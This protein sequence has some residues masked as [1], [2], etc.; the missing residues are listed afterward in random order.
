MRPWTAN[1]ILRDIIG[2]TA[3]ESLLQKQVS[4]HVLRHSIAS[5][6]LEQGVSIYQVRL[7]LGHSLLETTQI[8]THINRQQ[9]KELIQ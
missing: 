6:L 9:L 4:M 8:Y 3:N 7:F 2:R 1:Y 5:H